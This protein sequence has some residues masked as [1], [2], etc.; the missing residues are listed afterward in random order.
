MDR[1]KQIKNGVLLSYLTLFVS[2]ISQ[3]IITP[4]I[5]QAIG[6]AEHGVYT[7]AVSIVN[8]LNLLS[9]G[10]GS[11]YIKFYAEASRNSDINKISILNGSLFFLFTVISIIVFVSG[12]F[13]AKYCGILVKTSF[14]AGEI[15]ILQKT[16]LI[17]TLNLSL[18]F[19]GSVHSSYIIALERFTFQ[20][21]INLIKTVI[22]PILSLVLV[23]IGFK[24]F[25]LAISLV[26]MAQFVNFA[27]IYYAYKKHGF[28]MKIQLPKADLLKRIFEYSGYIFLIMILDQVNWN[29]D[30]LILGAMLSATAVSI[31]GVGSQFN[32]YFKTLS[33]SISSMYTPVIHKIQ[34][35][36]ESEENINNS[37]TDIM[38]KTGRIQFLVIMLAYTGF[39][40]FGQSFIEAWVGSVYREAYYVALLI[41]GSEIIPLIENVGIEIRR[42]KNKQKVPTYV[43]I[44]RAVFNLAISIPLCSRFGP[45]GCA[46]GTAISMVSGSVFLNFYYS[47]ALKLNIR[48]Y[49]KNILCIS[50]GM[51]LPCVFGILLNVFV[52]ISGYGQ[53]L[54]Y[55]LIYIAVYISSVYLFSFSRQEKEKIIGILKR[56]RG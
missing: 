31:Y 56:V 49:W 16:I 10:I 46:L 1:Q 5:I 48:L 7:M 23:Y 30:K 17:L 36:D 2:F 52:S 42:A 20:K 4:I 32:A 50:K 28:S 37:L 41:L 12:C 43:A 51:V 39:V 22:Q 40:F 8:Y 13:V 45:T 9:F 25:S 24:S 33:S 53:I 26:I 38:I 29:V 35:S 27:N 44:V 47:R 18:T 21:T 55:A 11:V 3:L 34:S 6:P 19:I 15:A 54:L 14:T